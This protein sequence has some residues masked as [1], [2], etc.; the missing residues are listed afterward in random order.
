M[1][2]PC[3]QEQDETFAICMGP[4]CIWPIL[5]GPFYGKG[6]ICMGPF[7]PCCACASPSLLGCEALERCRA[8]CA[9]VATGQ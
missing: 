1:S 9:I 2:Q 4:F 7:W 8:E 6:S 3:I 5:M